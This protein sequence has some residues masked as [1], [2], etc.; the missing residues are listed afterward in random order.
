[1]CPT[2]S[3]FQDKLSMVLYE[4]PDKVPDPLEADPIIQE[5]ISELKNHSVEQIAKVMNPLAE[6]ISYGL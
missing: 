2:K 3:A 5:A 1:M 4:D 6:K